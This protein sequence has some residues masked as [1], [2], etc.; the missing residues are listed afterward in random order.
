MSWRISTNRLSR[1]TSGKYPV[2]SY[3]INANR[4]ASYIPP[5]HY[6]ARSISSSSL[7]SKY[8]NNMSAADSAPVVPKT[9]GAS[10]PQPENWPAEKVRKTFIE[11]FT[12]Q[13]GFEHTFWPSAGVIPFDDDT[14]L[15]V[16]AVS[17]LALS[18][19]HGNAFHIVVCKADTI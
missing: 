4:K 17:I 18:L 16:N 2:I 3:I 1:L 19:V 6:F 10:W 13:P 5:S 7:L 12:Q 14:L 8:N 9:P 11:Y 15:F